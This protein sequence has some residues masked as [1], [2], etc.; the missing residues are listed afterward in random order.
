MTYLYQLRAFF[1]GHELEVQ[2]IGKT[3]DESSYMIGRFNT[4]SDTDVTAQLFGQEIM[5]LRKSKQNQ[6]IDICQY[7]CMCNSLYNVSQF[8]RPHGLYRSLT[9]SK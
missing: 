2:Q 6:V 3:S 1:T 9:K 5:N 4:D 7:I 8:F